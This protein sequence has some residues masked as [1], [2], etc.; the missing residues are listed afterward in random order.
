MYLEGATPGERT[1]NLI[2]T[3]SNNNAQAGNTKYPEPD[4]QVPAELPLLNPSMVVNDTFAQEIL[5]L[6]FL[7]A[8]SIRYTADWLR[9]SVKSPYPSESAFADPTVNPQ[10]DKVVILPASHIIEKATTLQ[11]GRLFGQLEQKIENNKA[12]S[13]ESAS[14]TNSLHGDSRLVDNKVAFNK[15][16]PSDSGYHTGLGTDT[17]SVCSLGSVAPPLVCL[18]I[19][20]KISLRSLDTR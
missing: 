15:S 6:H 2:N 8:P 1:G 14:D 13:K 7:G 5:P 16:V 19:S 10:S 12:G 4:I 20:C 11:Q 3:C 17:E 9:P 18:K